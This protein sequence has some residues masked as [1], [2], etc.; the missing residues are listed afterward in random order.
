MALMNDLSWVPALRTE[1]LT[2]LFT[3]ITL[4]GYQVFL[5]LFLSFGF[6]FW[7]TRIF[8]QAGLLLFFTAGVN[9]FLKDFYQDPRPDPIFAL[10]SRTGNSFGWPSGHA[11]MAIVL[12]GW[13]AIQVQ[14]IWLKI[15]LWTIAVL[16]C[17]SR[18]YLG[19]HDVGDVLGGILLGALTLY[20]WVK[21]DVA[22]RLIAGLELFGL[23]KLV[24]LLF[25]AQVIFVGLHFGGTLDFVGSWMWG[26]MM[27][28]FVGHETDKRR[29]FEL[30]GYLIIRLVICAVGA[31]LVFGA[32]IIS[33]RVL[34]LADDT[35]IGDVLAPYGSGVGYG[36]FMSLAIPWL[37]RLIAVGPLKR[38]E[39]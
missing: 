9:L 22:G 20:V 27:G 8:Y 36:L 3:N 39:T 4:L 6:Y 29:G 5:F 23:P 15:S 21:L 38:G 35:I 33:G 19:V 28:W 18:I 16:I 34:G 7:R 12:W 26:L 10:D 11:Q 1:A 24:L 30:Q 2:L 17:V 13:L 37:L 14:R 31:A 32:L 25:V